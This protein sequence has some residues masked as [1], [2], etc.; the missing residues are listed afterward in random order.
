M[1]P[2]QQHPTNPTITV[3]IVRGF[4]YDRGTFTTINAPVPLP[5]NVGSVVATGI[6]SAG[7]IVGYYNNFQGFLDDHGTFTLINVPGTIGIQPTAI[8]DAGQIVGT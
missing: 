2:G 5:A 6:N 1:C 4:L 8:N 7:Q 3:S